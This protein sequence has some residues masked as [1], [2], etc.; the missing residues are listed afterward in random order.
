MIALCPDVPTT[1]NYWGD[2]AGGFPPRR[3]VHSTPLFEDA[4]MNT[5][6]KRRTSP[7]TPRQP[8]HSPS[9]PELAWLY[10]AVGLGIAGLVLVAGFALDAGGPEGGAH[11]GG[12]ATP[13]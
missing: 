7:A 6:V 8:Q 5:T 10:A 3:P 13:V 2:A 11:A 1:R 9:A 4:V 12:A